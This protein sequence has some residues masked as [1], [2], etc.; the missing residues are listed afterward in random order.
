VNSIVQKIRAVLN[1]RRKACA[2]TG[3]RQ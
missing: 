1:D 3:R 2:V